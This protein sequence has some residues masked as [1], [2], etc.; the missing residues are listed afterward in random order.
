[1]Q[2]RH[3][4]CLTASCRTLLSATFLA[5]ALNSCAQTTSSVAVETGSPLTTSTQTPSTVASSPSSTTIWSDRF[6]AT[7]WKERWG[8]KSDRDWGW[9]NTQVIR[10]PSGKFSKVLRV[11]YPASSASPTVSRRDKAPLGGAQ[12]YANLRMS[13]RNS[14]R[15]SYYVRFSDNFDFVKGGKLPGLFGGM[16]ASG[17]NTPNGSDAFS[18]RFMWRR[19]GDGEVY[20]YLPTSSEYGTS[21]G[22]GRWRFQPGRWYRLEQEVRL[23]QPGKKNG[24]IRVWLD[25]RQVLDQSGL[26]FRTT[27]QL[28]L[29]GIFFST[30]FGGNDRSWATRRNVYVDFADFSVRAVN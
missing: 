11:H 25:G 9:Q 10:D 26:T 5:L 13:P 6:E 8:V 16:G 1:M 3:A 19:N 18:T 15:L 12:F 22:R 23:N 4:S 29:E 7:N 21:I 2:F 24:R 28:K 14:L 30:F 17:G 20:A 27:E